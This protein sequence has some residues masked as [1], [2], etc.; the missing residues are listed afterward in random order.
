MLN[1]LN[2]YYY[3]YYYYYCRHNHY[4]QRQVLS[5]ISSAVLMVAIVLPF[6][7]RRISLLLVGT[8]SCTNLGMH[9][10]LVFEYFFSYFKQ[11]Y[12]V[13]IFVLSTTL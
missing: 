5:H 11:K 1:I 10:L 2:Y 9:V 8:Y 7:F 6:H 12:Q 3:Y 4:H 13:Q